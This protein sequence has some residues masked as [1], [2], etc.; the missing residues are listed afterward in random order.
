M[1]KLRPSSI[2]MKASG[3]FLQA[4]DDILAIAD[5]AVRDSGA[6]L[7]QEFGVVLFGKFVIDDGPLVAPVP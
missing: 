7:A 1:P 6:D 2:P 3:R 5:A 4:V